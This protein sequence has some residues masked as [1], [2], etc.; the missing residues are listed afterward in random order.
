MIDERLSGTRCTSAQRNT[1]IIPIIFFGIVLGFA[2]WAALYL[3]YGKGGLAVVALIASV[4]TAVFVAMLVSGIVFKET[5]LLTGRSRGR[6]VNAQDS[7]TDFRWATGI[8]V[9]LIL[10]HLAVL[11]YFIAKD[12]G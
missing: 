1:V 7:P 6:W 2:C 12:I 11:G 10:F 5:V 4:S 8:Q 9:V 3:G